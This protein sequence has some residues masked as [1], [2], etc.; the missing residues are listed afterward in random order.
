MRPTCVDECA[1]RWDYQ[2]DS[3]FE[4]PTAPPSQYP[5]IGSIHERQLT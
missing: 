3:G 5:Q 2:E 1:V 4:V